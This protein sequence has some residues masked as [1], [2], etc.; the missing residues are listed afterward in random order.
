LCNSPK[1]GYN[2]AMENPKVAK[3]A[4]A[5]GEV[6]KTAIQVVERMMNLLDALAKHEDACS[7][8]ILAEQTALH[9][10]TAHRILNDMVACRLVER[11]DGG[12]YR[13]GLRLLE[14]GN[15]VKARLS[16]REAAQ[17]PMRALHK[18]TGET[19]NLSVR[20]GDEIVYVDRAYSERSGMQVVRAIGGR[21]PLH[22]TSVGKLFLASDDST[23]VRAYATRTG[24][25]GHTRNSITDL[26]KLE[27]ELAKVNQSGHASDDEELE[28][29]VSCL[30]AG[31]LDDTGKLVAGLS[32]SAPTDRIQADWLKVL[33]DTAMQ[34]SKGMGFT[35]K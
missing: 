9:P 7:L 6:G 5:P 22:L 19:I 18:I 24:L 15:L 34:I 32:L 4:K 12:T 13:L 29:G 28:L 14:L 3:M 21:A 17:A 31:I 16:V 11:G 27:S 2:E 10:S 1:N 30:A 35:S 20:Q 26:R 23:K 8:K 33:Q 25:A